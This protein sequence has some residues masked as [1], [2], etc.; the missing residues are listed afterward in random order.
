MRDTRPPSGGGGGGVTVPIA[1]AASRPAGPAPAPSAGP[2]GPQ[3][4]PYGAPGAQAGVGTEAIPRRVIRKPV[5]PQ[6]VV[7]VVQRKV[8]KKA[9]ERQEGEGQS[10]TSGENPPDNEL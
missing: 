3:A 9:M 7:P 6:P 5:S 1:A 2:S 10:D 4:S 8:I